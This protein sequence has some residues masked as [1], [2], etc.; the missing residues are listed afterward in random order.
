MIVETVNNKDFNQSIVA[1]ARELEITEG[2][3]SE[4]GISKF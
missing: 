3:I 4:E 1:G 2:S